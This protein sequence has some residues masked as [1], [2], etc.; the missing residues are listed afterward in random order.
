[1]DTFK[2]RGNNYIVSCE[3][4]LQTCK[5]EAK[6]L[7][8][9]TAASKKIHWSHPNFISFCLS[10]DDVLSFGVRRRYVTSSRQPLTTSGRVLQELS[11]VFPVARSIY[12]MCY[13]PN[14]GKRVKPEYAGI[15]GDLSSERRI[16]WI[17]VSLVERTMKAIIDQLLKSPELYYSKKSVMVHS[18]YSELFAFLMEGP[19][20]LSFSKMKSIDSSILNPG[21]TELVSRHSRVFSSGVGE[22]EGVAVGWADNSGDSSEMWEHVQSLYQSSFNS[23]IYGKNNILMYPPGINVPLQGYLTLAEVGDTFYIKWLPNTLINGSGIKWSHVL[24]VNVTQDIAHIH[25]HHKKVEQGVEQGAGS[26][27]DQ[28]QVLYSELIMIGYNGIAYPSLMFPQSSSMLRFLESLENALHPRGCLE[29][30]LWFLRQQHQRNRPNSLSSTI[31]KIAVYGS[32]ED[33]LEATPTDWELPPVWSQVF[34]VRVA[35]PHPPQQLEWTENEVE[36][37]S[38]PLSPSPVSPQTTAS[39][40]STSPLLMEDPF[41]WNDTKPHPLKKSNSRRY[42]MEKFQSKVSSQLLARYFYSWLSY[43]RHISRVKKS[44]SHLLLPSPSL[45]LSPSSPLSPASPLEIHLELEP[46]KLDKSLWEEFLSNRTSDMWNKI[47]KAIYNGGVDHPLRKE[48]WPYLLGVHSPLGDQSDQSHTSYANILTKWKRLEEQHYINNDPTSTSLNIRRGY[49]PT[50]TITT[51]TS[52]KTTPTHIEATPRATP[53]KIPDMIILEEEEDYS[54]NEDVVSSSEEEEGEELDSGCDDLIDDIP[55]TSGSSDGG[56]RRP[57]LLE[58]HERDQSEEIMDLRSEG[59]ELSKREGDFINELFK[60]DKDVPRCDR[61]YSFFRI[62]QNLTKLRNIITSYIWENMSNGYSQG[63]CDLLAPLL[64]ILEDEEIT[65]H[66]YCSLMERMESCFPPKPGVTQRM[67]NLQSLLQVLESDFYDY[68]NEMPMGDALFYTYRWF[69][70]NFKREFTY[71]DIFL[72][73]ETSWVARQLTTDN[74]EEFI[75]LGLLQEFKAPIMDAQ[76]DPS[77][78]LNLFTDLADSKNL[79]A[80]KIIST[81]KHTIETLQNAL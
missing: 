62:P 39:T 12:Q 61:D 65:F 73:W 37:T 8:E 54:H 80:R 50:S 55:R 32:T 4:L 17:R 66:C 75:A 3:T 68:L 38:V 70:V 63:M 9:T 6:K 57:R 28:Q 16:L 15:H 69:L 76:L 20:S 47:Q 40:G 45:P 58:S 24:S 22:G 56:E 35:K 43:C 46:Q 53:P 79:N 11:K 81:A 33:P 74:F 49:T 78:I 23:C 42:L 21:P 59:E 2:R 48:V 36:M 60:I 71:N 18:V 30:P 67:S 27:D 31:K 19:C 29:P 77:E 34:R 26:E 10:V 5:H 14:T 52:I 41:S 25:C 64:V 13:L 1:M 72:L 51:P 7:L 44:L